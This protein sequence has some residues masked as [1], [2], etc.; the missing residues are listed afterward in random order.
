MRGLSAKKSATVTDLKYVVSNLESDITEVNNLLQSQPEIT[1]LNDRISQLHDKI[2]QIDNSVK[3]HFHTLS[4]R[5]DG[6]ETENQELKSENGKLKN[7]VQS[8]KRQLK[9]NEKHYEEKLNTF[10]TELQSPSNHVGN[11]DK[12]QQVAGKVE[13]AFMIPADI[14]TSNKFSALDEG[15]T[16]SNHDAASSVPFPLAE[17]DLKEAALNP[18]KPAG[19]TEIQDSDKPT[20]GNQKFSETGNSQKSTHRKPVFKETRIL[21]KPEHRY[22]GKP[23]ISC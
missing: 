14:E 5:V 13:P 20:T 1:L 12:Q 4:E 2:S 18:P 15:T 16:E 17:D 21:Q 23:K 3:V 8:L 22:H 19:T 7:E 10:L 11:P 6:L 9:S